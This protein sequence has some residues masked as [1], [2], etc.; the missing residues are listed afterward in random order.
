[1]VVGLRTCYGG[2]YGGL[3]DFDTHSGVFSFLS[4]RDPNLL[5]SLDVY[6]GTGD[7]LRGLEMDDD[8]NKSHNRNHWGCRCLSTS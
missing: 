5:K 6:D 1:M 7:F 3:C 4:Y 2:A 8:T